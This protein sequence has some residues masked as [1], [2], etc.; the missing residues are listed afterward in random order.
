[1]GR[2]LAAVGFITSGIVLRRFTTLWTWKVK[3]WVDSNT[4]CY[5]R[6]I[7]KW[8]KQIAVTQARAIVQNCLWGCEALF[9]CPP[10]RE[11]VHCTCRTC[12]GLET[13]CGNAKFIAKANFKAKPEWSG[14][15]LSMRPMWTSWSC[16]W[17]V[18]HCGLCR[19]HPWHHSSE[20]KQHLVRS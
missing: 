14:P 8:V 20:G 4:H 6:K 10:P 18:H 11:N 5:H 2:R 9:S 12:D 1:M 19:C 3:S 15:C 17:M 16:G 7:N 13:H